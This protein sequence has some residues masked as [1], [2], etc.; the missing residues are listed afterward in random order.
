MVRETRQCIRTSWNPMVQPQRMGTLT[1]G[2]EDVMLGK[3]SQT[4][5]DSKCHLYERYDQSMKTENR[6][7]RGGGGQA[8]VFVKWMW[9]FCSGLGQWLSKASH[10]KGLVPRL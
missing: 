3:V 7:D 4:Q 2:L 8:V 6:M 9:C 5:I 1:H 10:V